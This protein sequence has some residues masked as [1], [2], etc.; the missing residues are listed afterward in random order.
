M[1]KILETLFS[2]KVAANERPI[3]DVTALV[4]VVDGLP[5][6]EYEDTGQ[7]TEGFAFLLCNHEIALPGLWEQN[8]MNATE[9]QSNHP[10]PSITFKMRTNSSVDGSLDIDVPLANTLFRNGRAFTLLASKWNRSSGSDVFERIQQAEKKSVTVCPASPDTIL[11]LHLEIPLVPL[12]PLRRVVSGL[13]NILRQVANREGEIVSASQELEASIDSYFEVRS[14]DKQTATVW[15]LLIPHSIVMNRRNSGI[16]EADPKQIR[17]LWT[18]TLES[19]INSYVGHWLLQGHGA[20]LH[21]VCMYTYPRHD[22][23]VELY[24][25]IETV[26]GGGGWGLKQGLLSLDPETTL[27]NSAVINH[28][29][30]SSHSSSEDQIQALGNIAMPGSW[31]QFLISHNDTPNRPPEIIDLGAAGSGS[32]SASN[33]SFGCIASTVDDIPQPSADSSTLSDDKDIQPPVSAYWGQFGA[34]S[35]TGIFIRAVDDGVANG[36]KIDVPNSEFRLA[37]INRAES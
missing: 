35:E 29:L 7:V 30:D 20:T 21:R 19:S 11:P 8:D 2:T 32:K 4:A 1:R 22:Y 13:G 16:S 36:S 14:L 25:L 28:N 5:S 24:K 34:M 10:R 31:V 3:L 26:S 17:I 18:N 27:L 23:E 9:Y 12:T 37:L 15:A 6:E 33:L